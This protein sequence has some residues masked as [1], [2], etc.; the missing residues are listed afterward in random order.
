[1]RGKPVVTLPRIT[2]AGAVRFPKAGERFGVILPGT[3]RGVSGRRERCSLSSSRAR[4]HG[5]GDKVK[6]QIVYDAWVD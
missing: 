6:W 1:M 5:E 3:A 4:H 2:E